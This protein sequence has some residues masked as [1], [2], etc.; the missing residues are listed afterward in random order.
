LRRE[1]YVLADVITGN[2]KR[3]PALGSALIAVEDQVKR[4]YLGVTAGSW[5]KRVRL[6]EL[7][8]LLDDI[9]RAELD[10]VLIQ[11]QQGGELVLYPLDNPQE[12]TAADRDAA[13][14]IGGT[15]LHIVYMRG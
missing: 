11:M 10:N 8:M 4:A 12:I 6:S 9:Q 5:N 3:V 1:G 14:A 13:I 2:A 7:R 15:R